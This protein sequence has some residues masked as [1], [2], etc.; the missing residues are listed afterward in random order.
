MCVLNTCDILLHMLNIFLQR[1]LAHL[2][3][4]A[5]MSH[6]QPWTLKPG[7]QLPNYILIYFCND[8]FE[9]IMLRFCVLKTF[10]SGLVV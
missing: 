7:T 10:K 1:T 3:S 2:F 4:F 6:E 5:Q 8:E 9:A